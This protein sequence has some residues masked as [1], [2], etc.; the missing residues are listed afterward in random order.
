LRKVPTIPR[1]AL[2]Y[3]Q[4]RVQGIQVQQDCLPFKAAYHSNPVC[5]KAPKGEADSPI[6]LVAALAKGSG[7]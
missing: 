4:I 1:T 7:H 2:A 5:P 3:G 6:C